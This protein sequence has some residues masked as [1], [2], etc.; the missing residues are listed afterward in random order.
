LKA[1]T[2]KALKL[3]AAGWT[4]FEMSVLLP[5]AEYYYPKQEWDPT[6]VSME[7]KNK[8]LTGIPLENKLWD[9]SR[10]QIVGSEF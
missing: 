1:E 4:G 3:Y 10:K 7:C 8:K 9:P 2:V 6:L 5:N